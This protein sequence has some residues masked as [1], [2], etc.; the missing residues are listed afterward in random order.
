MGR[1]RRAMR[2]RSDERLWPSALFDM[3][4]LSSPPLRIPCNLIFIFHFNHLH[5]V[6][7]IRTVCQLM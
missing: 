4:P 6:V 2:K 3:S 7:P 5:F 1:S